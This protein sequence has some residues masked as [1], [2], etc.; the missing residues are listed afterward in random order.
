MPNFTLVSLTSFTAHRWEVHREG[1]RHLPSL[2][3]AGHYLDPVQ[4]ETP[5][6][7]VARELALNDGE[8]RG[9]GWSAKDFKILPCC[10]RKG[11]TK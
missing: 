11:T 10:T 9:M 4:G 5:E 8:L 2:A 6:E 7:V 3:A 1:C